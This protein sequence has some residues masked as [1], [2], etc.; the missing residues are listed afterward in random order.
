MFTQEYTGTLGPSMRAVVPV[1]RRAAR[2]SRW[3]RSGITLDRIERQLTPR[4]VL[5]AAAAL[6]RARPR[7]RRRLADQP[8][9]PPADARA[10]RRGDHPDVRVLRR[11]PARRA[12][13]AAAGRHRGPGAAGQRRG[14]AGCSGSPAGVRRTPGRR[15]SACPSRWRRSALSTGPRGR[16]RSTWSA[17]GCSWSTR[18][19][20][21]GRAP[22]GTGGDPARPH[23]AA[24]ADRRARRRA[25][26]G[27]VAALADPRV[28]QPAAHRGLPDRARPRRRGGGVRH[29]GA[30]GRAAAH[31]PGGRRGRASRCSP[32]CCSASAPRPPS[33]AWSWSSTECHG[34]H[35]LSV[36]PR[37]LVTLVGNLLDNALDAVTDARRAP[38]ARSTWSPTPTSSGV[39]VDDSGPGLPP[40]LAD[41]RF[42]RAG[43]PRR[44]RPGGPRA[45]PGAGRPG[46][47]RG[48]AATVDVARSHARRCRVHTSGCTPGRRLEAAR[49]GPGAGRRGRGDRGARR[50]RR[51]ST[52][53]RVRGGRGGP[54]RR[55]GAAPPAPRRRGSTWSCSTCTCPT[56]TGWSCC[57]GCARPGILCDVI[58]V[59]SA[60]DL[61]VVRQAVS[62]GVVQYLLKPFTFA[63]FRDKLRAVRRL[64]RAARAPPRSRWCRTRSTSCSGCCAPAPATPRC[65]RG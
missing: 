34:V 28:G 59:T 37:D 56:C 23:R 15:R 39:R 16:T 24:G 9:A 4:L 54:V 6:A 35:D 64:P 19:R 29:R 7:C 14:R 5:I 31:R 17:T 12:G 21:P 65:R 63:G 51:T 3:S 50:T 41:R 32:R 52:G 38:G 22:V 10:G 20:P 45:R 18:R 53:C 26:P 25:R 43:P 55:R 8:P 60:R 44:G 13:G 11:G 48:T 46:G 62:Q 40:G 58:A 30:R 42:E 27:R 1:R 33:A 49:D 2:W 57:Q 36:E 61:D 47:A